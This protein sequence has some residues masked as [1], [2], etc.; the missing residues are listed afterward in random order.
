MEEIY[1]KVQ[2]LT[3]E[4]PLTA[5]GQTVLLWEAMSG[6]MPSSTQQKKVAVKNVSFNAKPGDRIGIIG[7]NGAGKTTLLQMIAKLAEPSSGVAEI[8][9]RVDCVMT[10]GVG[11]REE[12]T[13]H[14]NIMLDGE[15]HGLSGEQIQTVSKE[16]AEFADLG[17]FIGRPV[18][19]YSTGMKSRLAFAML[20]C[21]RPE[22][23]MIDETLSAG[24]HFF[25]HKATHK[26]K[27]ICLQGKILLMVSHN[28]ATIREMCN[29]C[30]WLHEGEVRMEGAPDQITESYLEFVRQKE[31]NSLLKLYQKHYF[32]RSY[33]DDF[34]IK[35]LQFLGAH[36]VAQKIFH[37]GDPFRIRV[38][39]CTGPEDVFGSIR[40]T[41]SRLDD[42]P[43]ICQEEIVEEGF[44]MGE[45]QWE[46][47][48]DPLLLG[49][50][51][52]EVRIQ[53]LGS[54]EWKGEILAESAAF[55]KVE[56]NEYVYENPV[57]WWPTDWRIE[58]MNREKE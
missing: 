47:S 53:L 51:G 39:F 9:G 7:E 14:E 57:Y 30:L 50:G 43:L 5:W 15:M 55:F 36:D 19:T 28:M 10:L 37:S 4:F 23:L 12:L 29:R 49:K 13:G 46:T 27:E 35:P 44:E 20:T 33:C 1:I 58:T 26:I 41:L 25:A 6:H 2:N 24:D 40:F 42:I 48:W 32:E 21:I 16:I 31:E 3:K 45:H 18:R 22:I 38:G 17:D 34:V 11:L 8:S 56:N 52:Y 54:K